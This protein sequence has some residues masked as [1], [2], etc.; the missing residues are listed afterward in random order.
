MRVDKIIF[1]SERREY[2]SKD[3]GK[4]EYQ[5]LNEW[6]AIHGEVT[7]II[8]IKEWVKKVFVSD[9][10]CASYIDLFCS[11]HGGCIKGHKVN[12]F[13]IVELKTP[14]DLAEQKKRD[15]RRQACRG[16][17]R[18]RCQGYKGG[19]TINEHKALEV[20]VV[21]KEAQQCVK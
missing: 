10:K 13:G 2:Q 6:L 16:E 11:V 21:I 15:N 8:S 17:D 5:L 7:Q 20:T 12:Y 19:Q 14:E 1:V 9:K 3:G 4:T 18:R